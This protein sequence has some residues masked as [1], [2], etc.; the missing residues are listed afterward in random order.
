MSNLSVRGVDDDAV[1]KLKDEAKAKARGLSLNAYLVEL[2][3]RNAGVTA[4]GGRHPLYRYL[5]DLAGTW[6]REDAQDFDESQ[7]AFA[8]VDEDLWR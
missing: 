3:Q 8:T 6:T 1:S 7:R 2:I 5:D 4:K